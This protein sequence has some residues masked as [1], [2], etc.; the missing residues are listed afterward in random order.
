[1][2]LPWQLTDGFLRCIPYQF[3]LAYLLL[4]AIVLLLSFTAASR[5]EPPP[6]HG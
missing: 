4:G 6:A 5:R 2:Y 1:M 3:G